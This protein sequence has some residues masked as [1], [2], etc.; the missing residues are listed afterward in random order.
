MTTLAEQKPVDALPPRKPR[1]GRVVEEQERSV[2]ST[3]DL[4]RP[5]VRYTLRII[6]VLIL[7]ALVI[8]AVG[9]LLWLAKSAVST[10]QDILVRPLELWPSGIQWQNLSTAFTRVNVGPALL[11]TLYIAFGS[12]IANLFVSTT[13]AYLLSVIRPRWSPL[14][15]GAI[16]ATLFIPGVVSLVPL[17]L[18]LVKLPVTGGS[19]I[20]TYWGLW[21]PAAANAFSILIIKR[22]FDAIP[23]ELF[24]AAKIDGAG[25]VRVLVLIVLPLSRPILGVVAL[26]T[27]IGSYKDYLL[28]LLVLPNPALQPISV[29]LPK[30]ASTSE[31]AIYIAALFLAVTIPIALFL[32]FQKQFLRGVGTAGAVKG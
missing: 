11:N 7:I 16:L 21:L 8:A 12:L 2:I 25:P 15:S 29:I 32:I 13:A 17:Y 26:L 20:N 10:T 19:L 30:L 6:Q 9:P 3:A 14:L 1:R 5:S 23:A 31:L 4:R 28:P 22:F 24:E 27:V 18:T